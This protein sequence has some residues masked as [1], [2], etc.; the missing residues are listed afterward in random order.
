M[1]GFIIPRENIDKAEV[2]GNIIK[3]DMFKVDKKKLFF[4]GVGDDIGRM[5]IIVG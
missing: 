2:G 3:A 1:E 5:K 4:T